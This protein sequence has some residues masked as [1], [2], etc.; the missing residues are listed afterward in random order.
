VHHAFRQI[1]REVARRNAE[2]QHHEASPTPVT[3]I[4]EHW[5]DFEG[6]WT[7]TASQWQ[8]EIS[9]SE[10]TLFRLVEHRH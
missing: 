2:L 10:R 5:E 6:L 9:G 3:T 8:V 1:G 4:A 7:W